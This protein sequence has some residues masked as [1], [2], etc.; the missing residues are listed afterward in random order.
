MSYQNSIA[1]ES[2]SLQNHIVRPCFIFITQNTPIMYNPDDESSNW[3]ILF[4]VL[5]LF[6]LLRNTWV[7]AMHI[8]LWWYMV[9]VRTKRE[10]IVSHQLGVL[11]GCME[12]PI[13]RYQCEWVGIAMQRMQES[14]K[15]MKAQQKKLSGCASNLLAHC[16]VSSLR[17][18]SPKRAGWCRTVA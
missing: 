3:F 1:K 7:Q 6:Q 17:W 10:K 5:Q 9:V 14:Y 18:I 16:Y 8:A 2:L 11:T 15:Y 13:N 12:I 4:N